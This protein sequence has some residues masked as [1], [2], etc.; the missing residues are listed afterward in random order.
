MPSFTKTLTSIMTGLFRNDP[1]ADPD[2]YVDNGEY[3]EDVAD[4]DLAEAAAS[5]RRLAEAMLQR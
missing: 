2:E 3:K 4:S 5:C 1:D